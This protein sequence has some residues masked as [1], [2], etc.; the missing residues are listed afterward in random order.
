MADVASLG[1]DLTNLLAL[2]CGRLVINSDLV[3]S[4]DFHSLRHT[5]TLVE[6]NYTRRELDG[7]LRARTP[8]HSKLSGLFRYFGCSRAPADDPK[9]KCTFPMRQCLSGYFGSWK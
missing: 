3:H 6:L 9:I 8:S 4:A 1:V 5:E 2:I 7:G